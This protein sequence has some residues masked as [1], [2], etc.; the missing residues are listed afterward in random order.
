V[1]GKDWW[2][3]LADSTGEQCIAVLDVA[4]VPKNVLL[5]EK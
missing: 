4:R 2:L 5:T 1:T 3:P